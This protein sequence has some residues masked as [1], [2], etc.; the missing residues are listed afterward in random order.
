MKQ[1]ALAD[2]I[3]LTKTDLADSGAL[4]ERLRRLN[5]GAAQFTALHGVVD[6]GLLFNSPVREPRLCESHAHSDD[7]TTFCLRRSEPLRR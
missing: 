2:R 6:A 3:V 7:V 4:A 5:P 1:A